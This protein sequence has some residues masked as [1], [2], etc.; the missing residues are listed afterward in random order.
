[1]N[2]EKVCTC[3][4]GPYDAHLYHTDTVDVAVRNVLLSLFFDG[5]QIVIMSGR[6]EDHR[7]VVDQWLTQKMIP[8]H[9]LIMRKSGDNRNDAI[10]KAELFDEFIAPK[11]NFQA[12][13]DDRDR[14]VTALRAKGVR[15]YQVAEGGF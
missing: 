15:V 3:S 5:Y 14:V 13:F 10:V 8:Y 2:S 12:Q 4:R 9:E 1:M 11:Y 6:S 7:A